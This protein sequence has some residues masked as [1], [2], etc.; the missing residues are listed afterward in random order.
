MALDELDRKAVAAIAGGDHDDIFE[1]AERAF[2]VKSVFR[3]VSGDGPGQQVALEEE[4]YEEPILD[5]AGNEVKDKS[6]A[7][8]TRPVTVRRIIPQ[9]QSTPRGAQDPE[10]AD[11][12]HWLNKMMKW[13]MMQS[14]MKGMQ[15]Q[16]M[17]GVPGMVTELV[18]VLDDEGRPMLDKMGQVV[19]LPKTTPA[20]A[21]PGPGG[22]DPMAFA[23]KHTENM[24]KIVEMMQNKE[25]GVYSPK[26]FFETALN[27]VEKANSAQ[28][29]ALKERV[30][31]YRNS[32]PLDGLTQTFDALEK[33]G[34]RIG[35]PTENLE[36]KKMD[37]EYLKYKIDKDDEWRRFLNDQDQREKDKQFASS[38]MDRV[39]DV[40]KEGID[41]VAGPLAN[42]FKDGLAT[43]MRQRAAAPPA[44]AAQPS[45]TQQPQQDQNGSIDQAA[46]R[47]MSNEELRAYLQHVDRAD[48]VVGATRKLVVAELGIRGLQV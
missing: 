30:E 6:G 1:K 13:T 36:A 28:V 14:M 46:I 19:T 43:V 15:G 18:P 31:D 27:L 38:Q 3:D 4:S 44:Q 26:D 20:P 11:M 35:Q 22:F 42:G 25:T 21:L 47:A 40:I 45:Q 2:V 8:K 39:T 29:D 7:V 32:N 12:D 10:E 48:G 5:A 34:V 24:L 33:V 41:K 9:G 37:N 17:T 16:G 23:E